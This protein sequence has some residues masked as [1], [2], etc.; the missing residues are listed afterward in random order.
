MEIS[1]YMISISLVPC[2]NGLGHIRRLTFLANKIPNNKKIFFFID[3]KKQKIFKL[4]KKI[5]KKYVKSNSFNYIEN[6][7]KNI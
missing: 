4:K 2:N 7:F 5:I 1:K 6:I 3:K